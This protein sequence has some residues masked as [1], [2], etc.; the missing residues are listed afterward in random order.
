M[1]FY[2]HFQYPLL[3]LSVISLFLYV[4]TFL[5]SLFLS[6]NFWIFLNAAKFNN[7]FFADILPYLQHI[8]F[9]SIYYLSLIIIRNFLSSFI[10]LLLFNL[11]KPSS[12]EKL[13]ASRYLAL[14]YSYIF[15]IAIYFKYVFKITY[16]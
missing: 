3:P 4:S 13:S 15:S 7:F 16:S 11:D 9:G 1:H 5:F 8:I 12:Q 14:T 10:T 2:V 6:L